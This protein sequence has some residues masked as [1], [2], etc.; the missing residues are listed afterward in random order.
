MLLLLNRNTATGTLAVGQGIRFTKDS[1]YSITDSKIIA[2]EG[3]AGIS[4]R[5]GNLVILHRRHY[6]LQCL[7]QVVPGGNALWGNPSTTQVALIVPYPNHPNQWFIFTADANFAEKGLCY[8]HI[9]MDFS[10]HSGLIL[11]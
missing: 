5:N 7:T 9:Q 1:A 6:R 11:G 4:D 3:C 2:S 8:T 10:G